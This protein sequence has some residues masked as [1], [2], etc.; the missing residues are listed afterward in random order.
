MALSHV[1]HA[2]LAAA[3]DRALGARHRAAVGHLRHAVDAVGRLPEDVPRG[4]ARAARQDPGRHALHRA[5]LCRGVAGR[6]ARLPWRH[7]RPGLRRHAP[8]GVPARAGAGDGRARARRARARHR[9]PLG[10]ARRRRPP[11]RPDR[12]L[13]ALPPLPVSRTAQLESWQDLLLHAETWR[14]AK[15]RELLREPGRT[16]QCIVAAA[17]VR[18]DFSRQR[19]GAVTLRLLSHLAEARRFAEWREELLEGRTVNS[20]ENRPAWHTA[21]RAADAPAE[22]KAALKDMRSLA[23]RIRQEGKYKRVVNLGTGGSDLGPR[24]LADA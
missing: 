14:D 24:L 11:G 17:G 5:A 20:T 7:P 21:L 3:L 16:S 15:L 19:L 22:V 8:C 9:R 12:A 4:R 1:L 6:G 23:Q 10:Q 2:R 13:P 18:Y